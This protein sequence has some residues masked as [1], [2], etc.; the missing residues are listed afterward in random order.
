[1]L[2][3]AGYVYCNLNTLEKW[4]GAADGNPM[5]LLGAYYSLPGHLE[6]GRIVSIAGTSYA[7]GMPVVFSIGDSIY[8][9]LIDDRVT[10]DEGSG[11]RSDESTG[12]A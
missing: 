11:V 6:H 1:L 12:G 7:V 9:E 8:V 3:L 2:A 10:T 5:S 4:D